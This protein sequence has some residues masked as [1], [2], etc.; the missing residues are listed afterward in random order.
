MTMLR[1]L[2]AVFILFGVMIFFPPFQNTSSSADDAQPYHIDS[3]GTV[4]WR[5]FNGYRRY[6]S[7]CHTCHGPDGLGS[8][9]APNLTESLKTMS[10]DQFVDVVVNGRVDVNTAADKRMPALGTN[11][12]VMCY[13]DDIYAYLKAR[14]DGVV[15]RGRPQKHANK[16]KEAADAEASCM[17]PATGN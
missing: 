5:I 16:S 11:P 6:H 4:D 17:G 14:S 3:D 8:S 1:L 9:F 13:I 12:N 15:G 2:G 7:I 10:Y